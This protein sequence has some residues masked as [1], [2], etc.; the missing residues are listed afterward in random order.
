LVIEVTNDSSVRFF[1]VCS[2]GAPVHTF[3]FKAVVAGSSY[4]L[5]EA[6]GIVAPL[7]KANV[8]PCLIFVQSIESVAGNEACLATRAFIKLDLEGVLLA[9]GR[10]LEGNKVLIRGQVRS[11]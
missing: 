4:R 5:L 6:G 11:S 2:D 3:G 7:E 9:F 1:F 8:S 10:S